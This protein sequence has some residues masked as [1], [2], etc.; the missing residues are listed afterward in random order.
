MWVCTLHF[1][2]IISIYTHCG[3]SPMAQ[4]VKNPPAVQEPRE[5]Q[6]C[7]LGW[8]DPLKEE[9]ASHS[10]VLAWEIHGQ[11]SLAGYSPRGCK[12]LDI[13]KH[14][15]TTHI[16]VLSYEEMIVMLSLGI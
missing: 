8:E 6:V 3:A 2:Y 10:S 16:V 14:M 12:E 7:S 9:L 5:M 13:T 4:Q 1:Y 15:R 11:K